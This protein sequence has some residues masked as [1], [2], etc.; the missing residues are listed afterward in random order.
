MKP[1]SLSSTGGDL[2]GELSFGV[3]VSSVVLR[4]SSSVVIS[5]AASD[6][7]DDQA[8]VSEH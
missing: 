3:V 5:D 4:A 2:G 7:V 6:V 1:P 8:P